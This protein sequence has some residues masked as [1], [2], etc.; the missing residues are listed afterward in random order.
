MMNALKSDLGGQ[1]PMLIAE[2]RFAA[3]KALRHPK[4]HGSHASGG[5][6]ASGAS[7]A[8]C[9]AHALGSSEEIIHMATNTPTNSTLTISQPAQFR[10]VLVSFLAAAMGSWPGWWLT[11]SIS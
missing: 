4:A 3:L 9:S 11:R 7:Q 1:S 2:A 5:A 8:L 6:Y 10:I